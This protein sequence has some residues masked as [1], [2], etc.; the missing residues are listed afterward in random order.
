MA[1]RAKAENPNPG[2]RKYLSDMNFMFSNR[3]RPRYTL[4]DL[5]RSNAHEGDHLDRGNAVAWL[6]QRADARSHES[7][8]VPTPD[9]RA[10]RGG[11]ALLPAIA[12]PAAMTAGETG[13]NPAL[14]PEHLPERSCH[15]ERD[16]LTACHVGNVSHARHLHELRGMGTAPHWS[17]STTY[18]R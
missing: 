15:R 9:R 2:C 13:R 8:V 7:N 5:R 12:I 14:L 11:R 16:L 6:D 4:R 1:A 10:F 18:R 17:T 3:S